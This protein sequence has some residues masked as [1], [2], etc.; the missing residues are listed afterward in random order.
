VFRLIFRL[1]SLGLLVSAAV[2][3]WRTWMVLGRTPRGARL[4]R[5]QASPN[6]RD[7][8][9]RFSEP[10]VVM[11]GKHK[12]KWSE[13]KD[14]F[15]GNE[16]LR[17]SPE[18]PLEVVRTD[19]AALPRDRD[20]LVWFGHSSYLLNL[21]GVRY[22]V[23]PVFGRASP[24]PLSGRPFPATY[25]YTAR[26]IPAVDFVVLTHD[27][28]DHL[29]W[30]T[31]RA[32]RKKAARFVCPLGVGEHLEKWGVA[33]DKIT[34]L[35]WGESDEAS[36]L[37][38]L[39]ARHFSG[40]TFK[41]NQS[42]WAAWLL[43]AGGRKLFLGGDGGYGKHFAATGEEHEGI[44]L[45]ILENG[46]YNDAWPLIHCRP[47]ELAQAVRDL[48]CKAFLTVHH[49]KYILSRHPW[50]EPW[51]NERAAAEE[52]GVPLLSP[53]MGEVLWLDELPPVTRGE[54]VP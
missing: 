29:E 11:D 38:A 46:Q 22:L 3:A 40:R 1:L 5:C 50:D 43:E 26:D 10:T 7:G 12:W 2:F 17:L 32:L 28:Y 39:P 13:T 41:R 34:E 53:R 20:W 30:P 21:G 31:V 42:L 15:F 49:G 48:R 37:T 27:H 18:T 52:T 45:A 33:P 9:F 4:A 25:R 36:G 35:D 8:A 14:F 54:P 19:L 51:E 47:A 6:W 24:I 44:D 23:D 16:E